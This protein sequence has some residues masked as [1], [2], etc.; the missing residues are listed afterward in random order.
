LAT[1][2][3]SS[4]NKGVQATLDGRRILVSKDVGTDRWAIAA[5][6]DDNTLSGNVFRTAGSP[7]AFV[8]C[9]Q[10]GDDFNPDIRKRVATY[11]CFGSDACP[12]VPCDLGAQWVLINDNVQLQGAFFLP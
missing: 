10:T 11:A 8:W 3:L 7:P 5:N 4:D 9:E 1:E 6:V 12:A 2:A